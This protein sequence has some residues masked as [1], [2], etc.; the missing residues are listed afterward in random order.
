MKMFKQILV[1]ILLLFCYNNILAVELRTDNNIDLWKLSLKYANINN[2]LPTQNLM[3]FNNSQISKDMDVKIEKKSKGKALF[4]SLLLPGMGQYYLG[5]KNYAKSFFY[6]EIALWVGA[7]SFK[8]Y[9]NWKRDDMKIF[10]SNHAN[11][12]V[13]GK[14]SQYFVD[15]ENFS[16]VFEY[17]DAQQRQ[18]EF[19]KVYNV[20]EYYW[21][22]DNAENQHSFEQM[23]LS[24]DRARNRSVF[25][26]GAIIANHLISAIDSV[27]K[28]Y[29]YN[30][31]LATHNNNDS[32]QIHFSSSYNGGLTLTMQKSF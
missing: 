11:A 20:N 24:S 18:R 27:W 13:G 14:K 17:N 1:L 15:M 10:A 6:T 22:W 8:A 3:S 28:T 23:R 29:K 5:H 4:Y 32:M 16:N 19:N 7:F 12:M 31:K 26:V 2:S 21:A 9:S 25:T 30:K